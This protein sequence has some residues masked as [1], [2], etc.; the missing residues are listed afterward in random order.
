MKVKKNPE[1]KYEHALD[2]LLECHWKYSFDSKQEGCIVLMHGKKI[3]GKFLLK[4]ITG[5]QQDIFK[6]YRTFEF[7]NIFNMG[8]NKTLNWLAY[9]LKQDIRIFQVNHYY[10]H[11]MYR[12]R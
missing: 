7:K 12:V 4:Q 5:S 1:T 2:F 9:F 6:F 3:I 11:A 8:A 10:H